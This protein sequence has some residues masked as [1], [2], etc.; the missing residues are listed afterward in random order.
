LL[1]GVIENGL[2]ILG[3]ATFW[4]LIVE[5]TILVFAVTAS[6]LLRRR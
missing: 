2:S 3:V 4:Q 1:L 6:G 5:G